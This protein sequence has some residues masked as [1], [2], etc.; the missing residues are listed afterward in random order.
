MRYSRVESGHHASATESV[1]LRRQPL[2]YRPEQLEFAREGILIARRGARPQVCD[3]LRGVVRRRSDPELLTRVLAVFDERLLN[4]I[5]VR[6]SRNEQSDPAVM[7]EV[8]A[9]HP[10]AGN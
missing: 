9:G 8:P 1:R 6:H 7:N 10:E 5:N 4:Q 3:W 2:A